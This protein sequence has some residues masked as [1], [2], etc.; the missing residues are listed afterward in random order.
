MI[1]H[2]Y[3]VFAKSKGG[4][5]MA[6]SLGNML[7]LLTLETLIGLC[8]F[9][10]VYC[11]TRHFNMSAG[12]GLGAVAAGLMGNSRPDSF[13]IYTICLFYPFPTRNS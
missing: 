4:Q 5:G 13:L 3:P 11:L 8:I 12:F 6:T 1:G 7:R 2:D 9:G 10:L